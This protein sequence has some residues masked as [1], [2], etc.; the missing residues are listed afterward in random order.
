MLMSAPTIHN[1][2]KPGEIAPFVLMPG[3]PIRARFIAEN[4]LEDAVLVNQI[5]GMYAFTGKHHGKPVTVMASGM[6]TSSMSIY[7]YELFNFY[8]VDT[9]I[10]VGS[11]GGMQPY[12]NL[13]DVV[14]G[15]SS[16]TDSSYP[17]LF[18]LPGN[19]SPTGD[20]LLAEKA[21]AYARENGIT[22]YCGP[23]FC[24]EAFYYDKETDMRK[25]ADMGLLA[26]EMESTAL[27]LNAAKAH[28]RALAICT[29]SDLIFTG[30]DCA[31][32]KR[33]TGFSNMIRMALSLND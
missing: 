22:A 23:V 17:S 26:V 11:A 1:S 12:L 32:E 18:K 27:Y 10:R 7:S 2:A 14:I 13:M 4:F 24:G 25:W 6:G 21:M 9:I 20:F 30:A 19:I 33:E 31:N 5:R 3:D 15:I 16:S 28:K 29:I 8:D